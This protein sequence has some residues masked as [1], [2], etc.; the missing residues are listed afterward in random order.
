VDWKN[1][2]RVYFKGVSHSEGLIEIIIYMIKV[3]VFG[4]EGID[5]NGY[6]LL[7]DYETSNNEYTSI[8][9]K[10]DCVYNDLLDEENSQYI[11]K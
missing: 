2:E 10:C 5:E 6:L 8:R 4:A 3:E 7:R 9:K 1:G 11:L